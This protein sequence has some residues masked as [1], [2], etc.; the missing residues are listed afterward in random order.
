MA[1]MGGISFAAVVAYTT[2]DRPR[3]VGLRCEAWGRV[4]EIHTNCM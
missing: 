1:L 3:V 4:S 2:W